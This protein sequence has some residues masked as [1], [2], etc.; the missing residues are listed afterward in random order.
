MLKIRAFVL[1]KARDWLDKNNYIEVQPPILIPALN[2]SSNSLN[3]SN[4]SKRMFLAKGS[5]P[6]GKTFADALERVYTIMPAFRIE[7]PSKRH[8]I[9]YWRLEVVQHSCL[10]EIM[11]T[12]EQLISHLCQCLSTER[13]ILERLNR[14][15][16]DLAGIQPPFS[17]LTYDEAVEILQNDGYDICWG[18]EISGELEKQLSQKF[19][20]PFF[21]WRYPVTSETFFAK[22][23]PE[24]PTIALYVD[25]IAPEG[26]GE[27]SSGLQLITEMSE[28]QQRLKKAKVNSESRKWFLELIQDDPRPCSGFA[29]GVERML[30]WLCKLPDISDAIAFPRSAN[31]LSP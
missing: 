10:T 26:Y 22:T 15:I 27:L 24:H 14:S 5:L 6:Y 13:K 17:R 18:Q 20:K 28:M 29:V 3:I 11:K 16:I 19:N 9:E 30:Q 4:L 31:N 1:K 23:D 12:Q 21:V 25:L 2:E 8:L 7:Q